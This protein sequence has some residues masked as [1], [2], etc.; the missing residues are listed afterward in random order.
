MHN[1][2]FFSTCLKH[3]QY[4]NKLNFYIGFKTHLTDHK[5]SEND[6]KDLNTKRCEMNRKRHKITWDAKQ[7][8][9]DTN[10]PQRHKTTV[11]L[12]PQWFNITVLTEMLCKELWELISLLELI[13][14]LLALRER[15]VRKCHKPTYNLHTDMQYRHTEKFCFLLT[16]IFES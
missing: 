14:T 16:Y 10:W 7:L 2:C 4:K 8:Q 12:C 15:K 6:Q 1:T 9:R 13:L 5:R 3:Q 11:S